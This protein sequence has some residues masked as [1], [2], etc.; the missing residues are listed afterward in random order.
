ML[1]QR[2]M[3]GPGL[4]MEGRMRPPATLPAQ[5][6]RLAMQ[7]CR[8]CRGWAAEMASTQGLD[9]LPEGLPPR[10]A[11]SLR[12]AGPG[13]WSSDGSLGDK[14]ALVSHHQESSQGLKTPQELSAALVMPGLHLNMP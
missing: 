7:H 11:A 13:T 1:I 14:Q 6:R 4:H 12:L 2:L 10:V 3:L 9:M 8:V 5:D